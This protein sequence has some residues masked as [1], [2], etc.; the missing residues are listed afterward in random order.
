MNTD[1]AHQVKTAFGI[2]LVISAVASALLGSLVVLH[3]EAGFL[4]RIILPMC[5]IGI[6][7][8]ACGLACAALATRGRWALPAVG[9]VLALAGAGLLSFGLWMEDISRDYLSAEYWTRTWSV[10][11]LALACA[12][13]A[14]LSLGRLAPRFVWLLGVAY[15]L[16]PVAAS[17]LVLLLNGVDDAPW[18]GEI[19]LVTLHLNFAV[20]ILIPVCH[21]LSRGSVSSAAPKRHR[22]TPLCATSRW[23]A[24]DESRF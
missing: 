1:Y 15:V 8:S 24:L 18:L 13:L 4:G 21:W 19:L 14:A 3:G 12:H 5:F 2:T 11:I 17:S 9:I 22:E 20:T 10:A 6:G 23:P 16:I 7:A